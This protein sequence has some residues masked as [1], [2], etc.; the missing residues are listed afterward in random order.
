MINQIKIGQFIAESR[1]ELGM[2][3]REVAEQIG[4]TDKTISKWETGNRLPDA[5]LLMDLCRV[6]KVDVNELLKGERFCPENY[7]KNA[8]DNLVDLVGEIN[9]IKQEKK[10]RYIGTFL[11]VASLVLG[12]GAVLLLSPGA[13]R[14]W[15]YVD[16]S[17]IAVFLGI[18]CL[19]WASAGC[20]HD[21]ISAWKICIFHRQISEK[22]G[23]TAVQTFSFACAVILI[24]GSIISL[25]GMIS[26]CG[27]WGETGNLGP[28]LAQTVL[29][30]LYTALLE[31]IHVIALYKLKRSG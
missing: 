10:G 17:V 15:D 22:E 20:F 2:T 27:Y 29:S 28:S 21:Y 7:G 23:K 24:V 8:A 31:L 13:V 18:L 30:L 11:G 12:I 6:L 9:G 16:I 26:L 19:V 1:R 4:V 25:A 5:S 3:Q 14:L